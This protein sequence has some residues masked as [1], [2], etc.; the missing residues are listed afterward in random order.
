[1]KKNLIID[2]SN[3]AYRCLFTATASNKPKKGKAS[4]FDD[5][6]TSQFKTEDEIYDYW[7]HLVVASVQ[8]YVSKSDYD[9]VIIAYDARH[10]WRKDIYPEYKGNRKKQRD[11]SIIN[12]DNFLPILDQFIL[13]FKAI[14]KSLY[15]IEIDNAEADDVA[16]VLTKHFSDSGESTELI[17]TDKDFNQLLKLKNVSIFNPIK[18]EMVK[19][20]NPEKELQI[21]CITGDRGDNIFAIKPKCGPATAEKLLRS[22]Q[23]AEFV[24]M[25]ESNLSTEQNLMVKNYKRNIQLIDF[26]YIPTTIKKSIINGYNDYKLDRFSQ[27]DVLHWCNKHNLKALSSQMLSNGSYPFMALYNKYNTRKKEETEFDVL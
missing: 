9:R 12:F 17:T 20:L 24:L 3:M 10:Y 4:V 19:C 27:V 1:M 15:H 2:F 5:D 16:A 18:K 7:R 6:F 13:E 14:F 8:A 11:D 23:L 22:G 25:E 21:K 26:E